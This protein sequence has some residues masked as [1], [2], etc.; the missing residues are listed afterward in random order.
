MMNF[1]R[2]LALL[3]ALASVAVS[4]QP[5]S[6]NETGFSSGQE[7][8]PIEQMTLNVP[9]G[10]K[11]NQEALNDGTIIMGFSKGDDYVTLYV[12]K[13]IGLDFNGIFLNGNKV[14]HGAMAETHGGMDWK[15]VQTSMQN[16]NDSSVTTYVKAFL[17]EFNG[18]SYYGYA[19]ST[20]SDSS[21]ADADAFLKGLTKTTARSLTG[22]GFKGHKYYFGWGAVMDGDPELMQNEVLYDVN[23][24]HDIFTKAVGGDYIGFKLFEH[25]ANNDT[26]TS[27]WRKLKDQMTSDDMYVQY[28][29][30]HG[31]QYELAVGVS[32]DD[33]RDAVLSMPAKEL[34]VFTMACE[35]GGLVDSFN[36]R[37]SDWENFQQQGRTLMVMSSSATS[38]MSQTGP[39]SDNEEAG[40]P[41]GSPGSAFGFALWKALI[42]HADGFSDG[43]KD[44][45]ISL[46]EIQDY[47]KNQTLQLT[48][49]ASGEA[50]TP[51][52][53]GS[54]NPGL[55]MNKV[56][57]KAF[58]ASLGIHSDRLSSS[59]IATRI[60]QLDR[61]MRVK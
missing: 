29:S 14:T 51:Q 41:V 45:F 27:E 33:I 25:D 8:L 36:N 12:K 55:I 24:T 32:Y 5:A 35:S 28:S 11:K 9:D 42:G 31:N 6:S 7:R 18:R 26:I 22:T 4:A 48:L 58:L 38:E 17:T 44:G 59:E 46:G 57:S 23:H 1:V 20:S 13:Q 47:V 53:T 50:Q 21:T 3:C 54:F 40:G 15:V 61:T 34:I 39:D 10:W 43:V 56:P 16:A 52:W 37:K 19:R 60:R 49:Q 30:G 2:G